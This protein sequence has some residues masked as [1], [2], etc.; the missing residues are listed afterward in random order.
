V[1]SGGHNGGRHIGPQGPT[2]RIPDLPPQDG[3]VRQAACAGHDPDHWY[4]PEQ[5]TYRYARAICAVC[6]VKT[7]CLNWALRAGEYQGMWGG[8]SPQQRRQLRKR[9]S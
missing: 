5:T 2:I 4:V 7:D 6:P 3:W 9:A 1:R 8:L